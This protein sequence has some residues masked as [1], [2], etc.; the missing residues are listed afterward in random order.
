M[1]KSLECCDDTQSLAYARQTLENLLLEEAS[2]VNTG[3]GQQPQAQQKIVAV[4]KVICNV[5]VI[6]RISGQL[7]T[8]PTVRHMWPTVLM[9]IYM[10]MYMY[11]HVC[12]WGLFFFLQDPFDD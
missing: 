11:I 1:Q 9:G 3:Q 12:R 6:I 2:D 5:A 7:C 4:Q 8:S 10:C